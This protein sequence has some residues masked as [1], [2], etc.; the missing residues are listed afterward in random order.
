MKRAHPESILQQAVVEYLAI[1]ERMGK[2]TYFSCPNEG[3]RSF[4]LAK[5]M[6][7]A[8]LRS[9]VSDL[10]ILFPGGRL[11]F[12]EL[13][14][15]GKKP[16]DEQDVFMETAKRLGH[17]AFWTDDFSFAKGYIDGLIKAFPANKRAA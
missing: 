11:A 17:L 3:K 10:C 15:P 7:K 2:L 1:Q 6:K 12:L 4:A 5:A 14:A 8:G 13:K 16:T 9:G